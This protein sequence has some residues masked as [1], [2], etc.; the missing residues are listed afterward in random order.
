VT[1]SEACRQRSADCFLCAQFAATEE[2]R[3][4]WLNLAQMWLQ[5]AQHLERQGQ[6]AEALLPGSKAPPA[7][8]SPGV[9]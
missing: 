1:S 2:A 6:D 5:L 7:V 8:E 3:A 9:D 4:A